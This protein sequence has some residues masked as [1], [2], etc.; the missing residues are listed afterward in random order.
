MSSESVAVLGLG[1]MGRAFAVNVAAAG[2]AVTGFNRTAR[3]ELKGLEFTIVSPAASAVEGAGIVLSMLTDAAATTAVLLAGDTLDALAPGAVVVNMATI[4]VAEIGELARS[5]ADARPD[6][7]FVDA[8]VSGSKGPA[9]QGRVTIL[10]SSDADDES[11]RARLA[12]V[13]EAIGRRTVWFGPTGAGSAMKIVVNTW[14]VH[15]MQGI[16]ETA[17]LADKFGIDPRAIADTLSGGPLDTPYATAKLRKI[18]AGDYST[19]MALSLGAKDAR[20]AVEAG[21]GLSLP[22]SQLI[23]SLW[24]EAAAE[25]S[26][27]TQDVSAVYEALRG[28]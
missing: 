6:I 26:L 16:A 11:L 10:A 8:P 22:V 4:G 12:P 7:V 15:V 1:A 13:F 21:T 2:I 24:A 14:L 27:A 25:E 23:A 5:L 20:L 28:V 17:L 18:D 9:E 19:E 3:D